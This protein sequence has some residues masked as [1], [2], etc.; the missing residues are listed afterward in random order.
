MKKN[1]LVHHHTSPGIGIDCG[2]HFMRFDMLP[3]SNVFPY[4]ELLFTL[5]FIANGIHYVFVTFVPVVCMRF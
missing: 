4:T 1:Q 3:L 5:Q 2:V